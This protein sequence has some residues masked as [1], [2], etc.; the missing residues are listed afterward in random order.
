MSAV[1]V[2]GEGEDRGQDESPHPLVSVAVGWRV[3]SEDDG[4]GGEM[5]SPL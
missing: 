5:S 3:V 1:A 4:C 2:K